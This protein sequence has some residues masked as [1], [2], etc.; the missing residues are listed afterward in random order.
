[1]S[2]LGSASHETEDLPLAAKHTKKRSGVDLWWLWLPFPRHGKFSAVINE[3]NAYVF[4]ISRP[5]P[6]VLSGLL[7][8][9]LLLL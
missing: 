8:L 1:M 6:A 2:G 9:L 3:A 7:R 5:I 4:C